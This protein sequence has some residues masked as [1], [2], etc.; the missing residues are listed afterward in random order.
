M[1][2]RADEG[3][4][5]TR[6]EMNL[7]KRQSAVFRLP[8]KKP[9]PN[10]TSRTDRRRNCLVRHRTPPLFLTKDDASTFPG[11]VGTNGKLNG[12]DFFANGLRL[13][14]FID[15]PDHI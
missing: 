11:R 5:A 9:Y 14:P 13:L 2:E 15:I 1:K 6:S 4:K 10:K 8:L 3:R 12:N 7:Q